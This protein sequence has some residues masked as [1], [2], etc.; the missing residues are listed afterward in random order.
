MMPSLLDRATTVLDTRTTRRSFI[1][2]AALA[3]SALTVAPLRY[4]LRPGSAYAAI[5][6]C[7]GQSCDC[8]S[9][10]CDGYTDFC[11]TVH[12]ENSCPPGTFAG[13][14]WKADGSAFCSGPRYYID[15]HHTCTCTSGCGPF[16]APECESTP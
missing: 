9:A 8:G 4:L 12:G 13:G 2:R 3:G 10:C 16:C 7:A 11:C 1:V 6:G 5:C 15:C 14:W